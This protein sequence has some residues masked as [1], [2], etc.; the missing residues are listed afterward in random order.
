MKTSIKLLVSAVLLCLCATFSF[1]QEKENPTVYY[2]VDYMKVNAGM[3]SK[4]L[5]LEKTWKKMH[6]VNIKSGRQ[7]NWNLEQVISPSGENVEY[8][9]VTSQAFVGEKQFAAYMENSDPFPGDWESMFT[10]EEA[11]LMMETNQIRTR[12]KSEIYAVVDQVFPANPTGGKYRMVNYF[13]FKDNVT[14]AD[15]VAMEKEIWRPIH[16]ARVDAGD[17]AGWGLGARVL[18]IG[19]DIPYDDITVDFYDN[20]LQ[21]MAPNWDKYFG[22]VHPNKS[23]DDLMDETGNAVI[24]VKADIRVLLDSTQ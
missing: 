17:M 10:H 21:M 22:K 6:E 11:S 14:R 3:H 2:V 15:H 18:P 23:I 8:N 7:A 24:R 9:Y 20:V 5:K 16:K 13:A 4:Y 12:V 1:A 19:S